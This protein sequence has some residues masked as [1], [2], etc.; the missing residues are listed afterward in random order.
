MAA[1]GSECSSALG[2]CAAGRVVPGA[3]DADERDCKVTHIVTAKPDVVTDSVFKKPLPLLSQPSALFPRVVRVSD[4]LHE[5]LR[6]L[7]D[8]AVLHD[9][10]H[11]TGLA[12]PLNHLTGLASPLRRLAFT[13]TGVA[14]TPHRA[15]THGN[16]GAE[17]KS[18]KSTSNSNSVNSISSNSISNSNKFD[19][20]V[21][22]RTERLHSISLVGKR[23]LLVDDSTMSL[24]IV[25]MLFKRL[26]CRCEFAENGLEA[27]TIIE[28]SLA[29]ASELV[30]GGASM[31]VDTGVEKSR[32]VQ[33]DVTQRE[34]QH[35]DVVG[36]ASSSTSQSLGF[37]FV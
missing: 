35:S 11:L 5:D 8:H 12:S 23:V 19:S 26:G 9:D 7:H 36:A 32:D 6:D 24:K 14:N 21:S 17:Y 2:L 34:N 18:T 33:G 27:M 31:G 20:S 10:S 22:F 28:N 1:C 15:G 13:A 3:Y 4:T 37:D 25:G 29:S 30:A 16:Y